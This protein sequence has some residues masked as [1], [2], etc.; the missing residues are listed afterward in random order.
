ML[1]AIREGRNVVIARDGK[2][3]LEIHR[4]SDGIVQ[5]IRDSMEQCNMDS[6]PD[7]T[8]SI[9]SKYV[10]NKYPADEEMTMQ[11]PE[12]KVSV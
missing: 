9:T 7:T 8:W 10:V 12:Y 11:A 6:H 1:S 3:L 5:N 2:I 4:V